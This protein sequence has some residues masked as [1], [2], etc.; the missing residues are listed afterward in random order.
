MLM[1]SELQVNS[2]Y[3]CIVNMLQTLTTHYKYICEFFAYTI[4]T[5]VNILQDWL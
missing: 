4:Q 5:V 1:S 2:F 3:L